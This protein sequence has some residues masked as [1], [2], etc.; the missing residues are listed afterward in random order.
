MASTLHKDIP[1]YSRNFLVDKGF[2]GR[3]AIF[4]ACGF[5]LWLPRRERSC[6]G[7]RLSRREL[8]AERHRV[9]AIGV[10]DVLS[11]AQFEW[12][13]ELTRRQIPGRRS[14]VEVLV[15]IEVEAGILRASCGRDPES[16]GNGLTVYLLGCGNHL[17]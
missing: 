3:K 6:A 4:A 17:L 13:G 15:V 1:N 7:R 16:R 11:Q 10:I 5:L 2:R 14:N 12:I 9:V 8:F